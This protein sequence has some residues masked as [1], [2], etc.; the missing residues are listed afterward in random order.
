MESGGVAQNWEITEVKD[1]R[2]KHGNSRA[3]SLVCVRRFESVGLYI[4]EV[5]IIADNLGERGFAYLS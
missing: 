5:A 3:R 1:S 2:G 4:I